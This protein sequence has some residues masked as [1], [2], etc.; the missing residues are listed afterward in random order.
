MSHYTFDRQRRGNIWSEFLSAQIL[1]VN[2]RTC[3]RTRINVGL[4]NWPIAVLAAQ[5]I[6][7]TCL[8]RAV[9]LTIIFGVWQQFTNLF[10]SQK[11][12][13]AWSSHQW[14]RV[15]C[16]ILEWKSSQQINGVLPHPEVSIYEHRTCGVCL[17]Y[18]SRQMNHPL[19]FDSVL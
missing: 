2:V 18:T 7:A 11:P 5:L 14:D 17:S 19:N 6:C 10:D 3:H 15:C 13:W 16:N 12:W 1:T 4:T 8:Y 9:S